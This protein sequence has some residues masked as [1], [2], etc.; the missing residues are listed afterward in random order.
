VEG[1]ESR[2]L[3]LTYKSALGWVGGGGIPTGPAFPHPRNLLNPLLFMQNKAILTQNHVAGPGKRAAI[4]GQGLPEPVLRTKD[5]KYTVYYRY[6][7]TGFYYYGARYLDPKT[8]RWISAVNLHMYHY[9]GNNPLKYTDPDGKSSDDM[10]DLVYRPWQDTTKVITGN[11]Q[12]FRD[13]KN[14][15]YSQLNDT[16]DIN[17]PTAPPGVDVEVN[18]GK[19]EAMKWLSYLL[20]GIGHIIKYIWFAYKVW[21]GHD[22]DFK[23][24]NIGDIDYQDFG[25]FHYGVVGAAA[26]IPSWILKRA[27][28]IAQLIADSWKPEFGHWYWK[29]PYGDDPR[30]QKYIEEGIT[31]YNIRR[32]RK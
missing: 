19:A 12:Y 31:Y 20:P 16:T 22:W 25:N 21:P 15:F 7:E 26:G 6:G 5:G 28:G 23:R 24:F 3:L 13:S 17:I 14:S 30:D 29:Y 10:S 9:A 2:K 18:I 1:G 8:S 27:A 11:W 4:C 32:K